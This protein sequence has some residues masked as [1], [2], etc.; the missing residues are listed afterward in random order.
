VCATCA[1]GEGGP[2]DGEYGS[3]ERLRLIDGLGKSVVR[4]GWDLLCYGEGILYGVPGT[5]CLTA[6]YRPTG[7]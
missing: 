4:H 3:T 7:G 2:G 5:L 1:H 6:D